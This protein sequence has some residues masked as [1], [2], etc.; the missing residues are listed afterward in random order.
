MSRRELEGQ[1]ALVTGGSGGIGRAVCAELAERGA[2]VVIVYAHAAEHAEETEKRCQ[3][4]GVQTLCV[5][6]D[7][8][9]WEECQEMFRKAVD[10]FGRIDILVNNAG[11]TRD[12]LLLRMKPEEFQ[13]VLDVNLTGTFHCMKLASRLML[14]QKY[15]RIISLSSVVGLYGNAGQVNYAASK[16]GVIGM[17]KSLA[18]ELASRN[19]TVNA[20]APGMIDTEMTASLPETVREQMIARI[21]LGRPGTA[22]E[23]AEAIAFLASPGASYI[24]GQVLGVDGGLQG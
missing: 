2:N 1:T 19:I 13:E 23:V 12:N 11:I 8:S 3:A 24:T 7:V 6:A 9:Q 5:H 17:T 10:R 14:R 16:A 21:P 4:E 15:G 22:E 20:V 18:K